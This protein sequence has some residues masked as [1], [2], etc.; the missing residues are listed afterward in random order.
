MSLAKVNVIWRIGF[1]LVLGAILGTF[2][3]IWVITKR[4]ETGDTINIG[5]IKIKN[6]SEIEMPFIIN[7]ESDPDREISKREQRKINRKLKKELP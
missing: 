7:P 1:I 3:T 5:K 6:A 4:L 2:A